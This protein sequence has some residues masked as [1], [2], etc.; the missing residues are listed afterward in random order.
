MERI[1]SKYEQQLMKFFLELFLFFFSENIELILLTVT[2]ILVILQ[3]ALN[4]IIHPLPIPPLDQPNHPAQHIQQPA[5]PA[6]RDQQE[7]VHQPMIRRSQRRKNP[8]NRL[9]L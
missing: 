5:Q 4:Y 2:C 6:R 1:C 8:P 9:N 3:R 7:H